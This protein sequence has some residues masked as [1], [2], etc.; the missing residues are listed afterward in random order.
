MYQKFGAKVSVIQHR[1]GKAH[2]KVKEAIDENN[3]NGVI[4]T[5]ARAAYHRIMK[6]ALGISQ[7][8]ILTADMVGDI[9]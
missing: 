8:E 7:G 6:D 5:S 2:P 4:L 9:T 3:V 1:Y